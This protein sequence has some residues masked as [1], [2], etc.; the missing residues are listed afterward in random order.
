MGTSKDQE[1]DQKNNIRVAILSTL[2][3]NMVLASNRMK[4]KLDQNHS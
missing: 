1:V 4:I 3:D 2:K